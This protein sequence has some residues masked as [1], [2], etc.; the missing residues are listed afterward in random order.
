MKKVISMLLALYMMFALCACGGHETA[1]KEQEIKPDSFTVED[2]EIEKFANGRMFFNVKVRNNTDADAAD[3]SMDYQLLDENGDSVFDSGFIAHNIFAGQSCWLGSYSI[4]DEDYKSAKTIR[5]VSYRAASGEDI[6]F[7][8]KAE[9]KLAELITAS[10]DGDDAVKN[11]I[12]FDTPVVLYE[13]ENVK[14]SLC[15][16][17]EEASSVSES[18]DK[19]LEF[20][21]E[22][23]SDYP[24]FIWGLSFYLDGKEMYDAHMQGQNDILSG[25]EASRSFII[26]YDETTP[27]ASLNELLTGE[28]AMSIEVKNAE[29]SKIIDHLSIPFSYD[30]SE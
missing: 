12:A 27:L 7:N 20:S 21:L 29:G 23:K 13:N 2:F 15:R 11:E 8:N 14:L 28:G 1:D 18:T 6:L 3:F 9:F 22:N 17:F 5:F 19:C 26:R 25:K 30:M 16:I 24:I 4:K 10:I